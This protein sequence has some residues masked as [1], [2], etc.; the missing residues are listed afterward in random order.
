MKPVKDLQ[1]DVIAFLRFPLIV[2]VVFVHNIGTT[3]PMPGGVTFGAAGN[4]PVF[5]FCSRLIPLMLVR[6]PLFFFISGFLFFRNIDGFSKHNYLQK[7]K[8]RGRTLLIPYLFWIL[9]VLLVYYIARHTP[10]LAAWFNGTVEYNFQYVLESLWGMRNETSSFYYP[11]VTQFWFIRD[12]MVAAVL[13]P[14]IYIYIKKTGVY[15]VALLGAL[16]FSNCWFH[17]ID[18]HGLSI[19]VVFF[20]TAGAWFGIHKRTFVDDMGKVKHWAY[21]LYPLLVAAD[22]LIKEHAANPFIH[23][24]GVLAGIVFWVSVAAHLLKTGKVGVNRFLVSAA[25]FLFAVHE[26]LLLSKIHKVIY[27]IFNPQSDGLITALYFLVVIV[28]VLIA[29]GLYYV[30][31]RFLPKFTALITGGR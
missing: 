12:L 28:T 17:F 26:P 15:G 1:S 8:N 21:A 25:F 23:N 24:A 22:M 18:T 13:T 6:V 10:V 20:F 3:V 9:A 30:L 7:L 11:F 19:V 27:V 14:V 4:L 16:W 5:D 29:L 31:R 2:G